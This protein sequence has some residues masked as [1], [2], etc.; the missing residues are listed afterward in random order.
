M[1]QSVLGG[2]SSQGSGSYTSSPVNEQLAPY[3]N[4]AP[5]VA[6]GL[7]NAFNLGPNGITAPGGAISPFTVNGQA[8]NSPNNP[9]V[10]PVTGAQASTL[11]TI[12]QTGTNLPSTM[13]PAF[14]AVSNFLNPNFASNLATSPQTAAAVN[15][16]ITPIQQQ[17]R[18]QT[19]P[20]LVGQSTQAGQRTQGSGG[21]G[22]SA[23]DQAFSAAQ[24]N[25]QATEAATAGNLVNAAYQTGVNINANA[26]SMLTGL[27]SGEVSNLVST[28]NAQALP[29]MT[30]QYGIT[31][32]LSLYQQQL[33][34]LMQ[35]LGL[36][37]QVSQP[38]IAYNTAGSNTSSSSASNG[39]GSL[40]SGGSN[41]AIAGLSTL[42]G[43]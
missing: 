18:T 29:Q 16:A 39:I 41:S 10:A 40:L 36:G 21:Q 13:A 34:T 2:S 31:Q 30:Q 27:T 9:L 28:L 22:S 32:G 24:G 4:L 12:G 20:G 6:S 37:G 33:S 26:P 38:A 42:F 3:T 11:G 17:F 8:S 19:E 23:F 25:E 15:A 35:A 5:S 1:A 7:S 43:G 14:N